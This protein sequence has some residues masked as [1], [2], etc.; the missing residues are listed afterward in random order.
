MLALKRHSSVLDTYNQAPQ[1][2]LCETNTLAL[3]LLFYLI[4]VCSGIATN[5]RSSP[6]KGSVNTSS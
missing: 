6:E 5:V 1:H 4:I 2:N 3:R